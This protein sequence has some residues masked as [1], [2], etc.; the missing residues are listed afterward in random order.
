MCVWIG[1]A[2][3][4]F[5]ARA[6]PFSMQTAAGTAAFA[7][8]RSA[9]ASTEATLRRAARRHGDRASASGVRQSSV[10][11]GLAGDDN[12]V[13]GR[14]S[15]RVTRWSYGG[16]QVERTA[17]TGSLVAT[18]SAREG[19]AAAQ[20]GRRRYDI[21]G[22]EQRTRGLASASTAVSLRTLTADA[23]RRWHNLRIKGASA[24]SCE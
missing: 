20:T 21:G 22:A 11:S 10:C 4:A 9:A 6:R 5:F 17:S 18:A 8:T 16:T 3:R 23:G 19:L 15:S 7:N 14:V 12:P 2:P 1:A 13:A 24:T